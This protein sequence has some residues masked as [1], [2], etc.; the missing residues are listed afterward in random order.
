MRNITLHD[1]SLLQFS[2]RLNCTEAPEVFRKLKAVKGSRRLI[3]ALLTA[4]LLTIECRFFVHVFTSSCSQQYFHIFPWRRFQTYVDS[5]IRSTVSTSEGSIYLTLISH[6]V[7]IDRRILKTFLVINFKL[8]QNINTKGTLTAL[9]VP[10]V[11]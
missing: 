3:F 6:N 8:N 10:C 11:F 1:P 4:L 9:L 5:K 7:T 2:S